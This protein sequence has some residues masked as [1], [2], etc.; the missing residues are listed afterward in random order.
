M[1]KR[2]PHPDND[3][4]DEL[5]EGGSAFQQSRSGGNVARDV[6]TR[7]ELDNVLRGEGV[8]RVTGKDNPAENAATGEKT[9]AKIRS[10]DQSR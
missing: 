2:D 4:I 10:G 8:E 6:G 7:A 3:L 9:A 1:T 5:T